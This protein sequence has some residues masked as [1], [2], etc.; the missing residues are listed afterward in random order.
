MDMDNNKR[1]ENINEANHYK[2]EGDNEIKTSCIMCKFKPNYLDAVSSYIS[3]ADK[4]HNLQEYKEEIYCREKLVLCHRNLESEWEEGNEYDKIAKIYLFNLQDFPKAMQSVQNAHNAFFTKGEYKNAIDCVNKLSTKFADMG[5]DSYVEKCLVIAFEA[6]LMVFH[7]IATKPEEPTDFIYDA[8]NNYFSILFKLDQIDNV[9]QSAEKVIKVVEPYE[10]D[11]SNVGN[12]YG[13]LLMGL[14]L[15][16][17][18][19]K[20]DTICSTVKGNLEYRSAESVYFVENIYDAIIN[21]KEEEF[22]DNV[23]R[24]EYNNEIIKYLHKYYKSYKETNEKVKDDD[25]IV[26]VVQ[27]DDLDNYL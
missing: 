11:K 7:T 19:I 8:I 14:M 3:A 22:K 4:F 21:F 5:E 24:L 2:A 13:Y 26:E 9:I 23:R 25:I 27:K 1:I 10:S 16:N 12:M 6:V 15:K 17:E 18:K 20:F